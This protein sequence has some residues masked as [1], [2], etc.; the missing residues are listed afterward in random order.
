MSAWEY[1][2][3]KA[4]KQLV[5]LAR[6]LAEV[7][8]LLA[9]PDD[10]MMHHCVNRCAPCSKGRSI[11]RCTGW[12]TV[13]DRGILAFRP[14]TVAGHDPVRI[15]LSAQV[16]FRRAQPEKSDK[17]QARPVGS[18]NVTVEIIDTATETLL[19][20]HHHD[21][22]NAGQV[23]PVWHFQYGGNPAGG[24][25]EL[26]TSWLE[27]PRWPQLPADLTLLADAIVYNFFVDEWRALN[28]KG[29]WVKLILEA[30]QLVMSHYAEYV[31]EHFAR[32]WTERDH[33]WLSAQAN[34][35]GGLQPRPA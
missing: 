19:E 6:L 22:A 28:A 31:H 18:A 35:L 26:P 24:I 7:E 2:C 10:G 21:L 32:P 23:G 13:V 16:S 1:S 8:V 25:G 15:D 11:K 4:C 17:W 34:A 5:L 33:T 3:E 27:P 14:Y 9:P 20:R 29:A 12:Q 30:E